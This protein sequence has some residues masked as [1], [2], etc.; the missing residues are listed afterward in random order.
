MRRDYDLRTPGQ[1]YGS[2]YVMFGGCEEPDGTQVRGRSE[3]D[4][5]L[6]EDCL[7]LIAGGPASSGGD[8]A[9]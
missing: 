4:P 1:Q 8:K 6:V 2:R 9:H 5:G 7:A 3:V